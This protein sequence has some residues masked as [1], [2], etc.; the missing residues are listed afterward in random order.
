MA[1]HVRSHHLQTSN[2]TQWSKL[3]CYS[4]FSQRNATM[5]QHNF[6]KQLKT[7]TERSNETLGDIMK[8]MVLWHT[9]TCSPV[10]RRSWNKKE[11]RIYHGW[12]QDFCTVLGEGL[13]IDK[14]VILQF[15]SSKS[16]YVSLC[17]ATNLGRSRLAHWIPPTKMVLFNLARWYHTT[18]IQRSNRRTRHNA[19]SKNEDK[20]RR[21][22]KI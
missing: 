11:M 6:E 18:K 15:C 21:S 4:I 16:T 2:Q 8:E 9:S 22:L 7:T 5:H 19:G 14:M 17:L 3:P 13:S 10:Q 1:A 12:I 20:M